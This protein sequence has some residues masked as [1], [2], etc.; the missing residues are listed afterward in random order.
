MLHSS[1]PFDRRSPRTS[2][3]SSDRIAW[4]QKQ[5]DLTLTVYFSFN[6]HLDWMYQDSNPCQHQPHLEMA[7]PSR[8]E[9][10]L[11]SCYMFLFSYCDTMRFVLASCYSSMW[12]HK[13]HLDLDH[14]NSSHVAQFQSTNGNDK[15]TDTNL[16][17]CFSWSLKTQLDMY[18]LSRVKTYLEEQAYIL[19]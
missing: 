10:C 2:F 1:P 14:A 18:L 17:A 6:Q 15:I 19:G 11:N 16:D 12:V 13:Q 7:Q 5:D 8:H 3:P 9:Y 4:K